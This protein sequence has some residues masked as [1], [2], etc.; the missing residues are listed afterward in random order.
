MRGCHSPA[1]GWI[2]LSEF[3]LASHKRHSAAP[4]AAAVSVSYG[5]PN[6]GKGGDGGLF[7]IGGKRLQRVETGPFLRFTEVAMEF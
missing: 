6:V 7:F 5:G 4:E 3:L 2:T 1:T